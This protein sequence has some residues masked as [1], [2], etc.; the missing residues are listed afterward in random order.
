MGRGTSGRGNSRYG[1]DE[2]EARYHAEEKVDSATALVT[3]ICVLFCV[4]L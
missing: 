3:F 1:V 4:A 2:S